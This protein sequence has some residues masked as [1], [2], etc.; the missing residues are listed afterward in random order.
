MCVVTCAQACEPS[1]GSRRMGRAAEPRGA[2]RREMSARATGGAAPG[3]DRR[4]GVVV[5][6]V[7]VAVF[8]RND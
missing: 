7:E 4:P 2:G 1:W 3:A 6:R 5:L 8:V